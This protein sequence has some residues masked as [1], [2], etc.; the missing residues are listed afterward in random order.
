MQKRL[1]LKASL[2]APFSTSV[3]PG[4]GSTQVARFGAGPGLL[5]VYRSF[6]LWSV[7]FGYA[8]SVPLLTGSCSLVGL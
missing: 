5:H 3:P 6:A 7:A 4:P 1:R 8:F 2:L